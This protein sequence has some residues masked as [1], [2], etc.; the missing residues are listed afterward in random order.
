MDRLSYCRL[1]RPDHPVIGEVLAALGL[2]VPQ[3]LS[4]RLFEVL[5]TW[6]GSTSEG[7]SLRDRYL[8]EV[9]A[10]ANLG[11]CFG[12]SVFGCA[13]L[14][15]LGVGAD[16]VCVVV[17]C[18]EGEDFQ[19]ALHASLVWKTDGGVWLVDLDKSSEDQACITVPSLRAF[20]RCTTLVCA[21]NDETGEVGPEDWPIPP[22]GGAQRPA[23]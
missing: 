22:A 6:H 20:A 23:G 1:V 14:R 9:A 3:E 11:L 7:V 15:A 21:F 18:H 17:G 13:I 19:D 4:R 10:D 8:S 2:P 5:W 16:K 12:T